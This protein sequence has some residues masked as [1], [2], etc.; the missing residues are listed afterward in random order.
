M[1]VVF[2]RELKALFRNIMAMICMALF[3]LASGVL[4]LVNNVLSGYGAINSVYSSMSLVVAVLLPAVVAA[5][6]TGERARGSYTFL[7]ALPVTPA[8][9]VLGKLL[10]IFVF[11]MI[12]TAVLA[13]YPL[14]LSAL[15]GSPIGVSLLMLV[16]LILNELFVIALCMMISALC[17]R[18]LWAMLISYGTL[19]LTFGLGMLAA[20]FDGF[21]NSALRFISPFRR[22][23]PVVFDLFDLSSVFFYLS[24]TAL[25]V[26]ITIRATDKVGAVRRK[27]GLAPVAALLCAVVLVCNVLVWILPDTVR[28]TD[29]SSNRLYTVSADS[30]K[31][32][33]SLDED[34]TVYLLNPSSAEEK[35]HSYIRRY[36]EQSDRI[37]LVEVDTTKETDFLEKHG[38]DSTPALYSMLVESSKRSKLV[39]SEEYFSYHHPEMGFMSPSEYE[40]GVNYYAQMYEVYAS[41]GQV[42]SSDLANLEEMLYSLTY[43]TTLCLDAERAITTAVEYVIAEQVPTLYFVS[44]HGEKNTGAGPLDISKLD[45]I[46]SDAALLIIND[47]DSDYTD[48]EIAMI[49]RYSDRG[50]RLLILTDSA[51]NAKPNLQRLLAC[52]GLSAAEGTVDPDGKG[53]VSATVNTASDVMASFPAKNVT[54]AGGSS[55]ITSEIERTEL[56][57]SSLLTATLPTDSDSEEKKDETV[58]LAVAVTEKGSKKLIWL[59][60]ADSFNLKSEDIPEDEKQGYAN[61]IYCLQASTAWLWSQFTSGISFPT[62]KAYMPAI[63]MPGN[64]MATFVGVVFIFLIPV[65]VIGCSMLLVYA[66]KRRS[67]A[68][69]IV[70]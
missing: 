38:I 29:I 3:V 39:T 27:A 28:Q 69:K 32:L 56:E 67:K 70:E 43:D 30:K 52:F 25:F 49:Q 62:A 44:N 19:L 13:V 23:D 50:G 42:S 10:G 31:L 17:K 22:F 18:T 4:F 2:G 26:F 9:R 8:A 35:L 33:S 61:A 51:I 46:P 12:P 24:L 11:F 37:K 16:V 6:F 45:E 63:I 48:A 36:C 58:T 5:S 1:G 64:G 34:V 41:S 57:F 65:T 21:L 47:P 55:V 59:T 40:Y 20:I 7:C 15:G 53:S 68:V 66:R 60:G 14:I 54:I